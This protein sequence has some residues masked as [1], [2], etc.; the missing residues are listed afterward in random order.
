MKYQP[1]DNNYTELVTLRENSLFPFG[2][3][4]RSSMSMCAIVHCEKWSV[5]LCVS[6]DGVRERE[7]ESERTN[8]PTR[9]LVRIQTTHQIFLYEFRS[10]FS[11]V[12]YAIALR[13]VTLTV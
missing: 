4:F 5:V 10:R 6:G 8:E 11:N 3:I 13:I 1:F 2:S 12:V 7:Q 9:D